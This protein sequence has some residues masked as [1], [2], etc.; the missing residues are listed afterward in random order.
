MK[1]FDELI[2]QRII[3]EEI[4]LNPEAEISL[5]AYLAT[6]KDESPALFVSSRAPHDRLKVKAVQNEI[7]K[8]LSRCNITCH[9]T[10]HIFRHTHT[11][12]LAEQGV[13]LDAIARRLGHADSTITK[14]VYYHVTKKQR[15]KDEAALAAVR[16]L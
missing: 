8:I 13:T 10:P 9:V 14:S 4:H 11:A 7:Q 12:L 3:K 5:R 6:R 2:R 16:I 1:N 15:Q